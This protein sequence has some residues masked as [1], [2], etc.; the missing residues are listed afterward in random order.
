MIARGA[1]ANDT[2]SGREAIGRSR[3]GLTTKIHLAADLRYRGRADARRPGRGQPGPGRGRVDAQEIP[4]Q[5]PAQQHVVA[6]PPGPLDR[7]LPERAPRLRLA[8]EVMR[9]AQCRKSPDEQPVVAQLA[10]E[11]D[12]LFS[13][14]PCR[15]D[16][17][18]ESV[19]RGGDQRHA[20]QHGVGAGAG[21][22]QRRHQQPEGL[23]LPR[24]RSPVA[25]ERDAQAQHQRGP[26]RAVGRVLGGAPQ[27]GLVGVQ[28]GQPAALLRPG[29]VRSRRLGHRQEMR[30]VRRGDRGGLILAG[31]EE[32]L[33][34]E[35]PDGLQ[36]PVPQPFSGGLGHDQ[37]LVHQRPEQAG[38]LQHVNAAEPAH[39][40]GRGQVEAAGEY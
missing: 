26:V 4:E 40:L 23:L 39:R 32:P 14:V 28:P 9:G 24:A 1:V 3:G 34:G 15:S 18:P 21:P 36:Q 19:V 35:Q 16:V 37:A 11:L 20:E 33:G 8:G 10:G 17:N 30:A 7:L 12:C 31:L 38:H 27:V 29:Q 13:Q 6:E 5:A 2:K 25:V 22:L